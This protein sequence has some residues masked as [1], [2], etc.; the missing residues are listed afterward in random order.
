[1]APSFDKAFYDRTF[2][3]VWAVL[4]REGVVRRCERLELAQ[5]VYLV[6]HRKLADRDPKVHELAWM[7]TIA[8]FIARR[9]RSLGRTRHEQPADQPDLVE[10]PVSSVPDPEDV[11]TWRD[12]YAEVVSGLSDERREVFEMAE[13]DGCTDEEIAQ[14]L[15]LKP[16]TVKS[17]LRTARAEVKAALARMGAREARVEGRAVALPLLLPFGVGAW[18][19]LARLFDDATPAMAEEAW[20]GVRRTLARVALVAATAGAVAGKTSAGPAFGA[21]WAL[22]AVMG[23]VLVA[24]VLTPA[25]P[26][27]TPAAASAPEAPVASA[28]GSAPPPP[29]DLVVTVS[30]A[31][32]APDAGLDA[33]AEQGRTKPGIMKTPTTRRAG[34]EGAEH[35]P[36]RVLGPDDE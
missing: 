36:H 32:Q 8:G 22:G 2:R 12:L 20:R 31:Q 23:G 15:R 27:T 17:R 9:H 21:G 26:S 33:T 19:P 6:A 25:W 34:S 35:D 4:R 16:G 30:G 13:L 24:I 29:A 7:G 1:M 28:M 3:H 5:D 14:A 10:E 11:A 18:R